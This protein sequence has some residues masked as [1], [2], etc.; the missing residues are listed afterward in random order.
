MQ[1][2]DQSRKLRLVDVLQLVDEQDHRGAGLFRSDPDLFQQGRQVRF[3]VAVIGKPGFGF[4]IEADLDIL[5]GDP[6]SLGKAR[7][8]AESS[9]RHILC[10][11]HSAQSQ[12]CDTQL[13]RQERR[14]RSPLR[15]LHAHGVHSVSF[16][17]DAYALEEYGLADSP[18]PDHEYTLG[19]VA[20]A[21]PLQRDPDDAAQLVSASQFRRRR[22]GSGRVWVMNGIHDH[23]KL[24]KVIFNR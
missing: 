20:D 4:E 16:G 23:A 10:R 22:A 18:E 14:Q 9:L 19:R 1:G 3:Q 12:Q 13:R 7:K 2:R 5:V 24:R 15:G 11:F 21:D 17:V 8:G 6:Q